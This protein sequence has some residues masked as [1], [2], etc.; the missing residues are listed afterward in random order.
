ML[1]SQT[2]VLNNCNLFPL[3]SRLPTQ[4]NY[5]NSSSTRRRRFYRSVFFVFLFI[6]CHPVIVKSQKMRA[7]VFA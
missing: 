6:S 7:T 4:F 1:G 5:G 3:A 2:E